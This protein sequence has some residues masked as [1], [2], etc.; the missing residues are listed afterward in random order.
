MTETTMEPTTET[1]RKQKKPVVK[2]R[3]KKVQTFRFAVQIA[4]VLLCA[5]IGVEFYFFTRYLE[6]GGTSTLVQRPPGAEGFLPIASL[7]SLY[8]WIVSGA[9]HPY[10]PAG[11]FI[12]VAILAVSWV[13]GKT[14]CSWLCPVGFISEMLGDFS[15]KLFGKN[16]TVPRWLDYPLRSLK[17]LLLGFFVWAIFFAMS[18][19]ALKT[20]LDSPYNLMSDVKMYY[21][22][23]DISRFALITVLIL[24]GLSLLVRG[25]WCRYLCPYGALLGVV[26]LLS[27]QKI[28]R[29]AESCI[30]CGK[31]AKVCPA[32]IKVD[33][34]RTVISDEC[35][36]CLACVDSCPIAQTLQV[37]SAV[38]RRPIRPRYIAYGVVGI[39]AAV[40]G[41]AMLTGH[42]RNEV[43]VDRYIL[44]QPV[45]NQLGHPTGAADINDLNQ[46][47]TE[48]P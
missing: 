11:L 45:V 22:F 41:L 13:F 14:F 8:Y 29:N 26:S 36:G 44:L 31:C 12:L 39:F 23:A 40:T 46:A 5:W 35:T 10:H 34:I 27:F 21:F 47:S 3:E 17:Y 6:S 1:G 7:M 16:L 9:V 32:H 43:P 30:D 2:N 25:F 33:K 15:K 20:F 38:T 24:V 19:A 48:K 18:T 37:R 28:R 4:F 42:W